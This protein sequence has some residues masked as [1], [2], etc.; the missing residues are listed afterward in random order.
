[1]QPLY[2]SIGS[3]YGETRRADP[4]ISHALAQYL[5]AGRAV[6]YLDLG[7]GT[8]NYTCALAELG[9]DWHGLDVSSKMLR[10]A[11][12]ASQLVTWQP[13]N[14]DALPYPDKTFAGV[15][16]TLAI[17]HF[18]SLTSSFSEVFRVLHAG[19]FI[20]FTAFPE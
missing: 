8:G 19:P 16:C 1:M 15:M 10:K 5:G 13:G 12:A 4:A 11:E 20:I 18:P 9:G 6:S 14:A 2:N 17:H 7:C 3:T